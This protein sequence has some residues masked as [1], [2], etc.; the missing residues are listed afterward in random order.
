MA[1]TRDELQTYRDLN[2]IA[3]ALEMISVYLGRIADCAEHSVY[4]VTGTELE[5]VKKVLEDMEE[6]G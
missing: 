6:G 1:P 5:Q 2:R 4:G 3:V